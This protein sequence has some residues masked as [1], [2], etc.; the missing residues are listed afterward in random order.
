VLVFAFFLRANLPR[1]VALGGG[2]GSSALALNASPRP[3]TQRTRWPSDQ[4][5]WA[6]LSRGV[7]GP[8]Q[9]VSA[10]PY[11]YSTSFPPTKFTF[12]RHA[13]GRRAGGAGLALG[14]SGVALDLTRV[15]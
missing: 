8:V 3:H 10:D 2:R 4:V 9:K 13:L 1:A 7:F 5:G 12:P 15:G 6:W 14:S 11:F